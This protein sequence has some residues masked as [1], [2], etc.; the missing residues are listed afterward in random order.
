MAQLP[1]SRIRIGS[2]PSPLALVQAEIVKAKIKHS[3]PDCELE[4][5]KVHSDGDLQSDR[6]ISELGGK[7]IFIKAL[8]VALMANEID[9]AVHSFKDI[10]SEIPEPLG[11]FGFLKAESNRDVVVS[12]GKR[13][14]ELK[15]GSTIGTGSVR[16]MA[17]LSLV[18][19]AL[20]CVP[21]RGNV[22][23]RVELVKSNAVDAVILSEAGLIRLNLAHLIDERLNSEQFLP[24]PGQGVMAIEARRNDLQFLEVLSR[25]SDPEQVQ[26]SALELQIMK[27][28]GFNCRIPFGLASRLLSDRVEIDVFLSNPDA[29]R[30]FRET[31][32]LPIHDLPAADA[33]GQE[34]R[35][36]SLTFGNG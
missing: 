22:G 17:Q 18:Y 19:P 25:I 29:S 6:P 8:E 14:N 7:G 23:T 21:V 9:I 33:W 24:A 10:T 13:L 32:Q 35:A 12:N 26:I 15:P 11:I 31:R 36:W 20:K 1:P 28:V 4:I 16:R 34:L 2:R 30:I 3:Y 27:S 5:V